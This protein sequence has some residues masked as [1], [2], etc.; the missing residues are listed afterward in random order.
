MANSQSPS[1]AESPVRAGA[2]SPLAARLGLLVLGPVVFF[3]GLEAALRLAGYGR[4][5]GLFIPDG[6]PGFYRTN[7]DFT[8]PFIPASFGIQPLNFRIQKHKE[9][10]HIRVFVLGESAAQGTP[11]PDFGFA[12]QLRAQLKARIPDREVEVYNLGITAINSHVVYQAARQLAGF[13]PDLLVV[14]MGNNEVVGPY[15]PG[16]AYLP[17]TPP[18]WFI[19]ASVWVRGTRVGQFVSEASTLLL[20]LGR[21]P[22]EWKGMET[23][24]ESAVRGDDPRLGLVY[25][26]FATNLR[27]ILDIAGRSG[28]KT[29][30]A[31]VVANLRDSAPFVSLHRAGLSPEEA[32]VW[33][34]ASDAGI[35]AWDLG[36]NESALYEFTEALRIDPQFA[37]THFRAGRL[38]EA[39][40]QSSLARGQYLDALHW[41]ALRFRPDAAI[42]ERIRQIARGAGSTVVLVD[43]AREMG[44][45][46]D[47]SAPPPGRDALFD[48]VH[49]NWE[50]NFR[51]A[52]LLADGC[53]RALLG[54]DAHTRDGLTAAGCATALGYTPVARLRMLNVLAQLTLRPPFTNQSTFSEDQAR[55]KKEIELLKAQF[56]TP[57]AKAADLDALKKAIQLDPDNAALAMRLGIMESEAGNFDR[58]LASFERAET[59]L[60]RSAEM[61]WRRAQVLI[62]MRRFDEAEALLLGSLAM[63]EAYYSAGG[64]LVELWAA[65]GQ[66]DKGRRFFTRELARAPSNHYLRLEYA[67]LLFMDG[68]WRGVETEARRIWD[69]DPRSRTATA[70][71]ELLVRLFERQRLKDA[72]DAISLA[73]RIPQAGDYFNNQRLVEIYAARGDPLGTAESLKALAASGPFDA[74]QHLDL[75]HRMSDLNRRREMLDELARAREVG[76]IEGDEPQLDAINK[77]IG[78]Y[79]RRFSDGQAQ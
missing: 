36:D 27:D 51:V 52:Q 10:G 55:L 8:S 67:N 30:L 49:F 47:S 20:H 59:L 57:E 7:P 18:A 9:T 33:K 78:I 16:C 29:V 63:D 75:A 25:E 53:I 69:D 50:G 37:E 35:I 46:P 44:S 2:S 40:G 28:V 48:H 12:A 74:A 62:R 13:A 60:P 56:G 39:L 73:A 4:P 76:Q 23:F 11:D 64:E 5:A 17:V 14:Y 21:R 26:N 15:G 6:R 54:R 3:C 1:K 79:R 61:S 72:A 42:N 22:L 58:A 66:L 68:D 65:T 24:S 31:T 45:D 19:R 32:K 38:E 71:L 43:A 70:A 77:M 34:A 41:D